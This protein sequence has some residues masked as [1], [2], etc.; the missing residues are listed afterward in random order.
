MAFAEKSRIRA[1][2]REPRTARFK[3]VRDVVISF[4]AGPVKVDSTCFSL[5]S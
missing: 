1:E 2:T 3:L 4:G 5:R